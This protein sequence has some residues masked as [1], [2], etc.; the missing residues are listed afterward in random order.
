MKPES[1]ERLP[2]LSA[3]EN[4]SLRQKVELLE[5]EVETLRQ[6]HGAARL[7]TPRLAPPR[8]R[9][10][11]LRGM[12]IV[13]VLLIVVGFVAGLLPKLRQ[14]QV[15]AAE[16]SQTLA[17]RPIVPA[18][19]V[20]PAPRETVVTLPG[21][22]QPITEAPVLARADGYIKRRSVDIGDR[23]AAG[24]V[25]A[26]IEAPELN[27]QV[28][29]A[30]AALDQAKSALEQAN[31][32]LAQGLANRELARVSAVRYGNLQK[33]GIVSRQEN[34]TYQAQYQASDAAVES[35]R[36]AVAGAENSIS[37]AQANLA[38]LKDMFSYLKV[39][40]PFAGIVTL[41][42]VDTGT[43]VTAGNTLLFRVAQTGVLRL[44]INVPQVNASQVRVGQTAELSLN[45]RPGQLFTAKIV[46][47]SDS[48][49]P[50]TRTML[51]EVQV[52]NPRGDL[53]PGMYA[54]VTLRAA[55]E[56]PPLLIPSEAL[57]ARAQGTMAAVVD[58]TGSVH[59]TPIQVG[60]DSGT[61]LE[62]L[63][64]LQEGM[65]VIVNPNDKVREGVL[66]E[67]RPFL[68]P[69]QAGS[70]A[71]AQPAPAAKKAS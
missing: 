2:A 20:I 38:R 62:V 48:L 24:Q 70:A 39:R 59:F 36:K 60:R 68:R 6:H 54:N 8:P 56:N 46:R 31:A 55:R 66:V 17:G 58:A 65:Q 28:L 13:L 44:Y 32:N 45:E 22:L 11:L 25:L 33:R 42:N 15:L 14:R 4:E 16:T 52:P 26:E 21:T 18:A 57:V 51:V 43:L 12:L 50:A 53:L 49:D 5:R 40:A 35:L 9:P 64:G 34:D 27:Q 67:T 23:V 47:S 19:V 37:A 71:P 7:E 69:R 10:S 41:R 3:E 61:E 63:S 1:P 30:A 29:Q